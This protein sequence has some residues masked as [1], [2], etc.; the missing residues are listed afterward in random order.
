MCR[1]KAKLYISLILHIATLAFTSL[2]A[3]AETV[4]INVHSLPVSLEWSDGWFSKSPTEYNHDLARVSATLSCL[5]YETN[6]DTSQLVDC[7]RALG[8]ETANIDLNYDLNYNDSVWGN[9]QCAFSLAVKHLSG[10][11]NLLIVVVRGTPSSMNE[12]LSNLNLGDNGQTERDLHEGFAKAS[13]QVELSIAAFVVKYKI[14]YDNTYVLI[15]GHSRGAAVANIV[16]Q[17]ISHVDF[18]S[19]DRVYA[20]TFASPNVTTVG[21]AKDSKYDYIWNIVNGEDVVPTVPLN[22]GRWTYTKWGQTRVL[23]NYWNIDAALFMDDRL[24][25]MNELFKSMM[26]RDYSP[27]FLG[28]FIPV[29]VTSTF[30]TRNADVS[31]FYHKTKARL[32]MLIDKVLLSPAI[33]GNADDEA[34]GKRNVIKRLVDWA[35]RRTDGFVSYALQALNDMHCSEGYLSWLLALDED[36]AF[37]TLGYSQIVIKGREEG[38]V[39]SDDGTVLARIMEGK[40]QLSSTKK[41]VGAFSMDGTHAAIGVPGNVNLHF[42]MTNESILPT[43]A[44]VTVEKYAADSTLLETS[45]AKRISPRL[46]VAYV[47]PIGASVLEKGEIETTK[48]RGRQTRRM[49]KGASLKANQVFRLA[50][51]IAFDTDRNLEADIRAGAEVF[52]VMAGVTFPLA[53]WGDR[54]DIEAGVGTQCTI[55]GPL[56]LDMA[57]L[58]KCSYVYAG[59]GKL[60]NFVPEARASFVVRPLRHLAIVTGASFDFHID[61]VNDAAFTDEARSKA[62]GEICVGEDVGIAPRIMMG[63]R[64]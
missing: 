62:L 23:V 10:G 56:V 18:F 44:W 54:F 19:T 40:V 8:I 31:D 43:P 61:G 20:Y 11:K 6:G 50:P 14:D 28:P 2:F 9:D 22:R 16:A 55:I 38:A 46:G 52:H 33:M 1:V 24:P 37:S 36:E 48:I 4:Q 3:A 39:L 17:D 45:N 7:Y 26:G 32:A 64:F 29:Q 58:A 30:V 57:A 21:D 63:I 35:N 27:W 13:K 47:W 15:T 42:V 51:E 41:P 5:S 25:R 34:G 60:C 53:R 59:E 12:W 49:M